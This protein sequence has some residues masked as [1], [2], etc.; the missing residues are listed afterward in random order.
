MEPGLA[1]GAVIDCKPLGNCWLDKLA[2]NLQIGGPET[3]SCR[4]ILFC[5]RA[6]VVSSTARASDGTPLRI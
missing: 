3:Y 1:Q 5:R 4:Y 2:N 6:G